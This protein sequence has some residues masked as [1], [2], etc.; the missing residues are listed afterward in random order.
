[1]WEN[2]FSEAEHETVLI[3]V[4]WQNLGLLQS[5]SHHS[6]AVEVTE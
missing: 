4:T 6:L 1:M 3:T 2:V 5:W